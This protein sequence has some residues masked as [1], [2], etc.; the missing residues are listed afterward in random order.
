MAEGKSRIGKSSA[1]Q[2]GLS[3][4]QYMKGLKS[5]RDL[6]DYRHKA[7]AKEPFNSASGKSSDT[8]PAAPAAKNTYAV[9]GDAVGAVAREYYKGGVM[10]EAP[11]WDVLD[12]EAQTE[13]FIDEGKSTIYEAAAVHPEDGSYASIDILRKVRGSDEWDLIEVKSST[14]VK[15][16]YINDLAFQA[17]VFKDA[18]YKIRKCSVMH[19]NNKYVRDGDIDPKQLFKVVDVTKK[20]EAKY[21]EVAENVARLNEM[22]ASDTPPASE[23]DGAGVQPEITPPAPEQ[24]KDSPF[25]WGL[26]SLRR[27]FNGLMNR[28]P[29]TPESAQDAAPAEVKNPGWNYD[30]ISDEKPGK[31]KHFVGEPGFSVTYAKNVEALAHGKNSAHADPDKIQE[32]MDE[33]EYPLY[34]L[35]YETVSSPIPLYDG[36]RPYQ[37]VPFQFSLHIQEEPGGALTHIEFLHQ[38]NTDPR[39]AFADKLVEVCGDK[40]SVIVYNQSFEESRNNELAEAFPEHKEAIEA[41]N[42]RMVDLLVPFRNR[43]LYHPEQQGSASLKYVLPAWTDVN[44]EN[45]G[46]ANGADAQDLYRDF[47]MGNMNAAEEKKLFEDLSAYCEKDTY[48]MVAL[49]AR[50][51]EILVMKSVPQLASDQ[52]EPEQATTKPKSPKPGPK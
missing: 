25:G 38:D 43:W 26:G 35:D 22:L 20:V 21:D 36:T 19:I 27:L 39:K 45:M 32:F 44:Y 24:P 30:A 37:Q 10:V 33:L 29:Q 51:D 11:Y 12:A 42:E 14:R 41:I 50:M 1:K 31:F 4:S 17:R 52:D 40:G 8:S 6:W 16:E 9:L 15:P 28:K 18:G 13:A 49:I 3:K 48:A 7:S 34:Y 47:A 2:V 46:I 23:N 5:E